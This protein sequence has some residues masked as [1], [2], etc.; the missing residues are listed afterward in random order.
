MV[1]V[2]VTVAPAAAHGERAQE[3]YLRMQTIAFSDVG[4]SASSLEQGQELTITGDATILDTW[5]ASLG[6]PTLGYVGVDAPGPVLLMKDRTING[7]SAPDAFFVKKSA[8][9]HFSMTLVA[10]RPG[11]WHI[12]PT[13]A[14][15]GAGTL[16][17]PGQWITIQDAAPGRPF[18]NPQQLLSGVSVD[19]ETYNLAQLTIWQWLGFGLGLAWVLYWTVPKPTMRRLAVA[20]QIPLN[21]DGRDVGLTDRRDHTVATWFAVAT[22]AML[23]GGWIY[24]QVYFPVKLPQQVARVR[25]ADLPPPSTFARVAVQRAE[26]DPRTSTLSLDIRAT[27]DGATAIVLTG[28]TTSSLTFVTAPLAD[29]EHTL[30]VDDSPTVPSGATQQLRIVMRDPVWSDDRL[31][32]IDNP[33]MYVAGQLVFE[34]EHGARSRTTILSNVVPKLF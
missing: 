20:S 17:G 29:G 16:I 13:F 23:A 15:Q 1:L 31:I 7:E 26:F 19:L 32:E 34:D 6:E 24:Q 2:L 9:Y 33:Q 12:H 18:S 10:R 11:R 4:F 5:P 3:G 30:T 21:N 8:S 22:V 27:N 14:V 28:F 25:P